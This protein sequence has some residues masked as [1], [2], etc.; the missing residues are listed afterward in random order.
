[1]SGIPKRDRWDGWVGLAWLLAVIA[2]VGGLALISSSGF[3]EVERYTSL[4]ST[5]ADTEPNFYIWAIAIG[6]AVSACLV[7][8]LFSIINSI[9]KNSC[10]LIGLQVQRVNDSAEDGRQQRATGIVVTSVP[11]HSPLYKVIEPG[12]RLMSINDSPISTTEAADDAIVIGYNSIEFYNARS[13]L[14][15]RKIKIQ[16]NHLLIEAK[17]T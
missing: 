14:V 11:T 16:G 7:A 17:S 10:D 13:K 8:A 5:T 6:Q 2:I 4:S 9:Y 1:M 12:D 15:S 3:V